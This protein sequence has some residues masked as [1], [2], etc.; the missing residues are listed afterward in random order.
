[1]PLCPPYASTSRI[2]RT[3]GRSLSCLELS[4]ASHLPHTLFLD[5]VIHLFLPTFS[6]HGQGQYTSAKAK[7]SFSRLPISH[8]NKQ[9]IPRNKG[10]GASPAYPTEKLETDQ[11]AQEFLVQVIPLHNVFLKSS[12]NQSSH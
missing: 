11:K 4:L 8:K 5:F 6:H 12:S 3:T 2:S 7:V 1:M 9:P 10:F